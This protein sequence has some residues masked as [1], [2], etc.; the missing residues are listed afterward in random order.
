M[1]HTFA[2]TEPSREEIDAMPGAVL[3][4]FGAPWCPWCQGVQPLLEQAFTSH[5]NVRH[6]KIED[7]R[8]KPLG[9]SFKVKLWPALIFMR[10]GIEVERLVRPDDAEAIAKALAAIDPP[11]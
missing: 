4:E 11:A 1:N 6:L 5:P 3:L 2:D 7:G 9:R 10:D 8:G